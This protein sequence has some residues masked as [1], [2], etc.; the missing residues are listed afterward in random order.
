MTKMD[1]PYADPEWVAV[2][3][4]KITKYNRTTPVMKGTIILKKDIPD[5]VLVSI[6]YSL[7]F[8]RM[9]LFIPLGHFQ[10]HIPNFRKYDRCSLLMSRH[11]ILRHSEDK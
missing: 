6:T 11:K 2:K 8:P 9:I 7:L 4:L 10:S 3:G 1:Q 5:T